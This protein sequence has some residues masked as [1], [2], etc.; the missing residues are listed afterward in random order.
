MAWGYAEASLSILPFVPGFRM[1]EIIKRRVGIQDPRFP[2]TT[3]LFRREKEAVVGFS[4]IIDAEPF[5][6]VVAKTV[7]V[8]NSHPA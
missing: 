3:V 5:A 8:F 4:G 2:C 7:T 6:R 1:G